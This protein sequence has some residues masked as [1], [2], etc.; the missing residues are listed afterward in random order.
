MNLR[1]T[2]WYFIIAICF[3][4]CE[5]LENAI[6]N[7]INEEPVLNIESQL[8]T[9]IG[10][11]NEFNQVGGNGFDSTIT[12]I[13]YLDTFFVKLN[14]DMT[15]TFSIE[16]D[17]DG[18]RESF[19]SNARE[20]SFPINDTHEYSEHYGHSNDLFDLRIP[21]SLKVQFWSAGGSGAGASTR[22]NRFEGEIQD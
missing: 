9:Y 8:G 19:V 18:Q 7:A 21:D 3:L 4:S 6:V 11:M 16:K 5:K 10:T 12:D 17:L 15:I 1:I 20:W 14:N 13:Y 2:C 22:Y